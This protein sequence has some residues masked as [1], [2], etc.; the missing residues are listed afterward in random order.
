M[1]L[2]RYLWAAPNTLVGLPFLL[3]VWL[4]RGNARIHAGVLEL[5]GGLLGP[6]LGRC[7][8]IDGG[9]AAMTFGHVVIA[10]DRCML[11]ATRTHERVH[12]RQCERWGPLFLPAY[13]LASIWAAVSGHDAYH[14]NYFERQ[15][16]LEERHP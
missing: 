12:V 9:A 6:L 7:V 13:A 1:R 2:V 8:P 4:T 5:H 16:T 3:V 11:D 14:D 15:A 10:R